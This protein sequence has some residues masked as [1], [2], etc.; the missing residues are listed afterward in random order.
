MMGIGLESNPR[1][2]G[3]G[4][5]DAPFRCHGSSLNH[6]PI[7]DTVALPIWSN[8]SEPTEN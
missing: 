7:F 1:F 5:R 8:C 2:L 6:N 4:D 3:Q